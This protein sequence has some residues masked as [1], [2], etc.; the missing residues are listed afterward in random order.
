MARLSADTIMSAYYAAL[1]SDT[2]V[3]SGLDEGP[4]F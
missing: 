1:P 2:A 3:M 4:P